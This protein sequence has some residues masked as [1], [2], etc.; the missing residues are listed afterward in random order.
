MAWLKDNQKPLL[1][2]SFFSSLFH[3]H[4]LSLDLRLQ[5]CMVRGDLNP[6]P[7]HLKPCLHRR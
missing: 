5:L 1:G 7:V 2:Y 6:H 3:P 4:V